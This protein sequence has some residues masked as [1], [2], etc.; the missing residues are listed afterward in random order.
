MPRPRE[1]W[2]KKTP[3]QKAPTLIVTAE[4]TYFVELSVIV[5]LKNLSSELRSAIA[6]F[7]SIP[8]HQSCLADDVAPDCGIDDLP[9]R[10]LRQGQRRVERVQPKI[11]AMYAGWREW[12]VILAFSEIVHFLQGVGWQLVLDDLG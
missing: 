1:L 3:G 8:A 6:A 7:S 2:R 9:F 12:A 4:T 11:V 10:R 5:V